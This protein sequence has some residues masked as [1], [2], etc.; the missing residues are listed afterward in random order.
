MR[1]GR[2]RCN[3]SNW[4]KFRK[5]SRRKTFIG[6]PVSG[7]SS[8]RM[9]WRRPFAKRVARRRHMVSLRFKRVPTTRGA[10]PASSP[11]TPNANNS[12]ISDGSSCPSPSMVAIQRPF[13][14]LMPVLRAPDLPQRLLC[15]RTR[16]PCRPEIVCRAWINF[17]S[18][19]STLPSSTKT[20]SQSGRFGRTEANS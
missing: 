20:I 14:F 19:P 7:H 18:V 3:P 8:A 5:S 16:N 10:R 2:K 13:A 17:S 4:G 6:A 15:L 9:R 1:A 12:G 11:E